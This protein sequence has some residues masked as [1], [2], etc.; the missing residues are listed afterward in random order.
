MKSILPVRKLLGLVER[1]FGLVIA[2]FSL[3]EW[4]AV[5][6]L[7]FELICCDLNYKSSFSQLP[8]TIQENKHILILKRAVSFREGSKTRLRRAA[9][10][11]P[12][13]NGRLAYQ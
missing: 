7:L 3:P 2:V 6:P 1:T 11:K 5:S 4:Q 12:G 9:M 10:I 13:G 8:L